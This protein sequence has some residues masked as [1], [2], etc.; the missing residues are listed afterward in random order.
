MCLIVNMRDFKDTRQ[1]ESFHDMSFADGLE[2][3]LINA[4]L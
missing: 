3:R 1:V 2:S 4:V